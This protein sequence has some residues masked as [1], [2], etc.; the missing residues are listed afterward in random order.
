MSASVALDRLHTWQRSVLANLPT[1]LYSA[2]RLAAELSESPIDL[3]VKM[4]A[5]TGFALGG[6][7][8][9]KLEFELAPES[10]VARSFL[11]LGR[12]VIRRVLDDPGP[13]L[14]G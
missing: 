12:E 13:P 4:D 2:R 8:V 14:Q 3:F 9:R 7:K 10:R 11:E 6:N 5:E 1:P